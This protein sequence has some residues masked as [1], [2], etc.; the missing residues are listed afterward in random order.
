MVKRK[1]TIDS[2]ARAARGRLGRGKRADFLPDYQP[3]TPPDSHDI[4]A[5]AL[6]CRS[7]SVYGLRVMLEVMLFCLLE[8]VGSVKKV[9]TIGGHGRSF[10][11]RHH[12]D[13]PGNTDGFGIALTRRRLFPGKVEE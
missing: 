12:P 1:T 10:L 9:K 13:K 5:V 8:V 3:R 6:T 7:A 11:A 2:K 4:A